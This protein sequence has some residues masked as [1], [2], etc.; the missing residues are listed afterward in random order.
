[1]KTKSKKNTVK[2]HEITSKQS[3]EKQDAQKHIDVLKNCQSPV[4]P[5]T[6]E[7]VLKQTL[8]V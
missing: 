2:R 3:P 5:A 6:S 7:R 8:F 1:M 4:A